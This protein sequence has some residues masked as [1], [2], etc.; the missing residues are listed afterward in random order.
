MTG[1]SSNTKHNSNNADAVEVTPNARNAEATLSLNSTRNVSLAM[2]ATNENPIDVISLTDS[3]SDNDN[4]KASNIN[5]AAIE[6]TK[7]PTK[8]LDSFFH[9][10]RAL[11]IDDSDSE[12]DDVELLGHGSVFDKK[13]KAES[14]TAQPGAVE[15]AKPNYASSS[16]K[17]RRALDSD[18]DDSDDEDDELLFGRGSVFDKKPKTRFPKLRRTTANAKALQSTQE[19]AKP[20]ALTKAKETIKQEEGSLQIDLTQSPSASKKCRSTVEAKPD[21][22]AKAKEKVKQEGS[23]KIDLTET[24]SDSKKILSTEEAKPAALAKSEENVKQEEGSLK[25]DLTK[26][27]SDSKKFR[28]NEKAI[29]MDLAQSPPSDSSSVLR[30]KDDDT[31]KPLPTETKAQDLK[32]ECRYHLNSL[33]RNH[34]RA[35]QLLLWEIGFTYSVYAHQF[36]AIRFVAGLVS[37]FP[38]PPNVNER[39][40]W[41]AWDSDGAQLRRTALEGAALEFTS[42]QT[43]S[44]NN[45]TAGDGDRY[46]LPTKGM[47]LADEMGLGTY[48]GSI[49]V[50]WF[51]LRLDSL[52]FAAT[53]TNADFI[54]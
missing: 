41:S 9:K 54:A 7:E 45:N 1:A 51:L 29:K 42:P 18:D 52:D 49:C 26:S 32:E 37:S 31:K 35:L 16:S 2:D 21:A 28:S 27:P 5:L 23:L 33:N 4:D 34:D 8:P 11:D 15:D 50:G 53:H 24:T 48:C 25:I 40:N 46:T 12:D 20:A 14:P 44:S 17:R 19:P 3:E 39:K 43:N 38:I 10:Y 47:L 30:G 22:L 6:Q 13:P 36:E